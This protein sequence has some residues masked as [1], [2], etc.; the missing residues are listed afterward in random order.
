MEPSYHTSQGPCNEGKSGQ[1]N[2]SHTFRL[3]K[4]FQQSQPFQANLKTPSLWHKVQ[5]SW[6]DLCF[7]WKQISEG[8]CWWQGIWLGPSHLA[9]PTGLG[10]GSNPV[11]GVYQ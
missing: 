3:F 10:S 7:P 5:C 1:A 9:S 2:R 8:G 4:G 11:P 6:L